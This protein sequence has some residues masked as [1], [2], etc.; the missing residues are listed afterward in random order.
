MGGAVMARRP[1]SQ[2]KVTDTLLLDI[3]ERLGKVETQNTQIL[4]NETRAAD[5]RSKMYQAQEALRG[6]VR[7]VNTKLDAV[8]NRVTS[9]EPDV[10]RMK[11]FRAQLAI[12]VFIVTSA[13]TGAIN[14]V[15]IGVTHFSEIKTAVREFLR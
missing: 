14:L 11:G 1:T 9:M 7:E 8:T 15:W 2:R 10:T 3:Y 4:E 6:D 13:V 12:A 5:G